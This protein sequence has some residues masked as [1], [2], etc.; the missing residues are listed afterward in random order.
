MQKKTN[1]AKY[2]VISFKKK[3]TEILKNLSAVPSSAQLLIILLS[4]F[5]NPSPLMNTFAHH[6]EHN[7]LYSLLFKYAINLTLA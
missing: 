5:L 2:S 3:P 7:L 1:R 4:Y 6:T